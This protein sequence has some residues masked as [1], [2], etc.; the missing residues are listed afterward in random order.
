MIGAHSRFQ[1]QPLAQLRPP[2][3]AQDIAYRDGDGLLLPDQ[4]DQPSPV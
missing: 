4:H 2:P 3:P 1:C